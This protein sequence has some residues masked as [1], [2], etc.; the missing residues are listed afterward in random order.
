MKKKILLGLLAVVMCF[1]L[2]G[3]GEEEPQDINDL[4]NGG[5]SSEKGNNDNA[6]DEINLYSD[7]TKMVFD[8]SGIYKIVYYY[9]GEKITGLE[10][11]YNYESKEVAKLAV[12][13]LK[14]QYTEEDNIDSITQ[15]GGY[16]IIKF[17]EEEY[18]D[19]TV[20]EVKDTYS[21]LEQV[22]ENN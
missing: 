3:C 19:T 16:V 12:T 20:Q 4:L 1:T 17:K 6:D 11:Y 7:N 9:K 10:Y 8:F 2:T 14:T 5:G 18:K 13:S 22:Y 15:K 21:F